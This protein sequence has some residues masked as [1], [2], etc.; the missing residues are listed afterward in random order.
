MLQPQAKS[1]RLETYGL[2]FPSPAN[3]IYGREHCTT[4]SFTYCI[5]FLTRFLSF[6][7]FLV[8]SKLRDFASFESFPQICGSTATFSLWVPSNG[9]S[10]THNLRASSL[11]HKDSCIHHLQTFF[12]EG[13]IV[14][15]LYILYVFFWSAFCLFRC[16]GP[17]LFCA[18][19]ESGCLTFNVVSFSWNLYSVKQFWGPLE[20]SSWILSS[21]IHLPSNSE[22][23]IWNIRTAVSING[24]LCLWKTTLT[25]NLIYV[26]FS[27][28]D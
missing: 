9:L 21:G 3:L 18:I 16:N 11:R 14:Q 6:E 24:K 25:D 15:Q 1:L 22:L 12:V 20:S 5:L 19:S 7:R 10:G 4:T 2:Q 28:F 27:P 13:S 8:F 23:P 26:F 17:L